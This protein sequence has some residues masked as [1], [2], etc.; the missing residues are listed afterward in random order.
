MMCLICVCVCVCVCVFAFVQHNVRRTS[1]WNLTKHQRTNTKLRTL[2]TRPRKFSRYF[3]ST[4]LCQQMYN[5]TCVLVFV[6]V[7]RVGNIFWLKLVFGLGVKFLV[8]VFGIFSKSG[9]SCSP[10]KVCFRGPRTFAHISVYVCVRYGYVL[11]YTIIVYYFG[12][13]NYFVYMYKRM[14]FIN[15]I[16][17]NFCFHDFWEGAKMNKQF[18]DHIWH[19]NRY[20]MVPINL[21]VSSLKR[22][23]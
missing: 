17:N 16:E 5:K 21:S 2:N 11:G 15:Y 20:I 14:Y 22:V 1:A 19:E 23:S 10:R 7:W 8:L 4:P 12:W 13:L 9:V 6:C 18:H 3:Q